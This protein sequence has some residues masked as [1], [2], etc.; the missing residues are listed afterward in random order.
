[1]LHDGFLVDEETNVVSF[2]NEKEEAA[3]RA[4][5]SE[6]TDLV[7]SGNVQYRNSRMV[8]WLFPLLRILAASSEY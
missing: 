5:S 3:C 6:F 2:A 7:T 8:V 4:F 1:M